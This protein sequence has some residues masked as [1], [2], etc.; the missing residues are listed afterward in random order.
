MIGCL[1]DVPKV[2]QKVEPISLLLSWKFELQSQIRREIDLVNQVCVTAGSIL[3]V[4]FENDY[5]TTAEIHKLCK[6]CPEAV[7]CH[8]NVVLS[9]VERL[10]NIKQIGR[11][12]PS[13]IQ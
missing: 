10:A 4:I 5:I 6:I 7:K 8:A 12:N 1:C 9:T 11:R 13:A 2:V 3:K